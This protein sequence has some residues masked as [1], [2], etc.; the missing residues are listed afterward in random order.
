MAEAPRAGLLFLFL[1]AGLVQ[2]LKKLVIGIDYE[3][4]AGISH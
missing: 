2:I 4:I 1:Q 3:D